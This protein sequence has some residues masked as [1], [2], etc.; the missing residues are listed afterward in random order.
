VKGLRIP[1]PWTFAFL[2]ALGLLIF[3]RACVPQLWGPSLPAS[4]VRR[5]VDAHTECIGID[6]APVWPGEPRQAQCST[7]AVDVLAS[8]R[9]PSSA[10]AGLTRAVC[11]RTTIEHPYWQTQGQTRHEI[12]TASRVAYKV[13]ILQDG[14]WRIFPDDDI[15]DRERWALYD[16]PVAQP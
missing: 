16:C 14:R 2:V 1:R 3:L 13:A 8:G 5:I 6:E 12:L 10:P 4:L 15:A 9:I 11:Y 7:V